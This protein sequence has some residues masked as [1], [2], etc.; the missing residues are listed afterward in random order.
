MLDE[1]YHCSRAS[2]GGEMS[3]VVDDVDEGHHLPSTV[4]SAH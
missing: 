3:A 4:F 1:F 2:E